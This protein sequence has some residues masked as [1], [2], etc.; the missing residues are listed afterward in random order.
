M[1]GCE[2]LH[3]DCLELLK[4]IRDGS[5]DMILCDLPY[6]TTACRWDVVIPFEPLWE[7]YNR[8]IKENGAIVLF[9]SEPFSTE[10]R[11]SNLKMFKYDWIW[12]KSRTVG[13]LNAKNAPLKNYEV[14]SVFSKGTTANGSDRRM[15]YFPQG[16]VE[17]NKTRKSVQQAADTVVWNRPGRAKEYT[18]K[19][20]GYPT[21]ILK[22]NNE[23]KQ[24]HPT[25]KP[26]ELCEYL[27]K[28]YTNEGDIVLD[29]CMGSGSVGV[30]CVNTG[31][32]FIGMELDKGY[33]DIAVQRIEEA[34]TRLF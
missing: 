17:V 16:L 30:A 13:F 4:D 22:F 10:L 14:V 34:Q 20:A 31:R 24:V 12:R 27:I 2:L 8:I 18:A 25:Q 15:K 5:V 28:T 21:A 7:Q 26:V 11:H 33:F 29:N 23:A 32:R 1:T 9:G 19:F 6:G 3:G